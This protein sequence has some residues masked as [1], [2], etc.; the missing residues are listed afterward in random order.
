MEYYN[1]CAVV[2]HKL[3]LSLL[4]TLQASLWSDPDLVLL[5]YLRDGRFAETGNF[6]AL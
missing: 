2:V 6:D 5:V 3:Q 4:A 1:D